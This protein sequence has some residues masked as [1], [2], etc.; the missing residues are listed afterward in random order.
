MI[1]M[2]TSTIHITRLLLSVFGAA[3]VLAPLSAHALIEDD[4]RCRYDVLLQVVICPKDDIT[5]KTPCCGEACDCDSQPTNATL[6][7]GSGLNTFL[8]TSLSEYL[9]T[10]FPAGYEYE[11]YTNE[12]TDAQGYIIARVIPAADYQE[13]NVSCVIDYRSERDGINIEMTCGVVER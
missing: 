9:D 10:H 13:E 2:H 11:A 8:D 7:A 3:S 5:N 1:D 4:D 12:V 6:P